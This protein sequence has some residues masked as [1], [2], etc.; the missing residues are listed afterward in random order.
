MLQ[1][2]LAS[3]ENISL[4]RLRPRIEEIVA[5]RLASIPRLVDNFVAGGIEVF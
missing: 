2:K 5:Y 3:R 1:L 4:D